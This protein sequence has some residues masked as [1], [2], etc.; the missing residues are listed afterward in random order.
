MA[1]GRRLDAHPGPE[2][3]EALGAVEGA[4]VAPSERR[5]EIAPAIELDEPLPSSGRRIVADQRSPAPRRD[6]IVT[7]DERASERVDAVVIERE[8]PGGSDPRSEPLARAVVHVGMIQ[9]VA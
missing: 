5:D 1:R 6:V 4:V 8:G 3:G 9:F 2:S 7:G